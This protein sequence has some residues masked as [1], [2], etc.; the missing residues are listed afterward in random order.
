[1]IFF[2]TIKYLVSKQASSHKTSASYAII[3]VL[4][5]RSYWSKLHH[6]RRTF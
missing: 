4:F 2:E 5:L 1:M 6:S 3:V